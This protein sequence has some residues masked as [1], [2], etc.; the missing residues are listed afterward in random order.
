MKIISQFLYSYTD[1]FI[2]TQ[3]VEWSE[4]PL[5]KKPNFQYR[6]KTGFQRVLDSSDS[7]IRTRAGE[8]YRLGLLR[9]S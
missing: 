8:A 7:T 9:A 4:E 2:K 6:N 5:A 3:W 1:Q